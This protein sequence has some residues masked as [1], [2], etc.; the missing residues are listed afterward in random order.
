MLRDLLLLVYCGAVGFVS[1]GI[2]TSC[3]TMVTAEPARFSLFGRTILG[4]TTSFF[5]NMLTGPV[6]VS[7]HVFCNRRTARRPFLSL[8]AGFLIA[9]LWSCCTGVVVLRLLVTVR[10]G[11]V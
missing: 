10:D 7:A 1:A 5:F 2:A 4:L 6:V 8:L 3:Y 11:L 9:A